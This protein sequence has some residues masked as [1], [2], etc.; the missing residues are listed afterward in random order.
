MYQRDRK[1]NNKRK[2]RKR[3]KPKKGSY[4]EKNGI[5]RKCAREKPVE[6]PIP[7]KNQIKLKK[8]VFHE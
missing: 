4:W 7:Q 6:D 5:E 2:Y 1:I 8:I 3:Q